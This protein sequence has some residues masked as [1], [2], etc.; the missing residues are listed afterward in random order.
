M[1]A[2][3]P[4]PLPLQKTLFERLNDDPTGE[5][6]C[7]FVAQFEHEK[8]ILEYQLQQTTPVEPA[9]QTL[10]ASKVDAFEAAGKIVQAAEDSFAPSPLSGAAPPAQAQQDATSLLSDADIEAGTKTFLLKT[11]LLGVEMQYHASVKVI[12]DAL[13][14]ISPGL[15]VAKLLDAH[16]LCRVSDTFEGRH[17][18]LQVIEEFPDFQIARAVLALEDRVANLDGWRGL[19]EEVVAQGGDQTSQ[20]VAS[21]VLRR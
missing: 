11:A 18:L 6:L 8:A 4:S 21:F 15:A 7:Q 9:V 17:K 13:I 10:L 16:L 14:R 12:L 5:L 19:A 1:N 20:E 3:N 2:D